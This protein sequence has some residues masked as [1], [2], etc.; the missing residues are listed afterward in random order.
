VTASQFTRTTDI[1]DTHGFVQF[2]GSV[3]DFGAALISAFGDAHTL[4]QT[5]VDPNSDFTTHA[6]VIINDDERI[7]SVP[8]NSW[9]GF[10]GGTWEQR[11]PSEMNGAVYTQVDESGG[12]SVSY[13]PT[14][15][16]ARTGPFDPARS[17]YNQT[18][19]NMQLWRAWLGRARGGLAGV[20]LGWIGDSIT[21]GYLTNIGTEDPVS[22]LRDLIN[23][24]DYNPGE[25]V[26]L[27]NSSV[28][29]SRVERNNW[30]N[31]TQAAPYMSSTAGGQTMT[32]TSTAKGTVVEILS[33]GDGSAFTYSIDGGDPVTVTGTSG[34][35]ILTQVTGLD[36]TTHTVVLTATATGCY[37]AAVGVNDGT[38][39][40]LMNAAQSGSTTADW[41]GSNAYYD[42]INM[43]ISGAAPDVCFVELGGNDYGVLGLDATT[44]GN[45]LA[46]IVNKL[47]TAGVIVFLAASGQA[48]PE[49]YYPQIYTV[50][51]T[52]NVPLLDFQDL[53]ATLPNDLKEADH[54]HF[55]KAGYAIKAEAWA[56]L[57]QLP[58]PN[59]LA[60]A[61]GG[62]GVPAA[63]FP[64]TSGESNYSRVI[65]MRHDN[66]ATISGYLLLNYFEA[67]KTEAITKI[68]SIAG[69]TPSD[70]TATVQQVGV[71]SVADNGDLT[72]IASIAHDAT[73]WT[74][75]YTD[76]LDDLDVTFDKV[77][78]VTYAIGF[79]AVSTGALCN[80]VGPST[81]S[82]GILADALRR[83][84]PI[85]GLVAGLSALPSTVVAGAI[86][87]G[88]ILQMYFELV[89]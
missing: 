2:G 18:G 47:Q 63:L 66:I 76:Y 79:L 49:D 68:R 28:E 72:L 19:P 53:I 59:T 62:G 37:V 70:G 80:L 15:A 88:G 48:L 29:D 11:A 38:G 61:G 20:R 69:S 23:A 34:E 67:E 54:L 44:Y 14:Y 33:T 6:Q 16:G 89:P 86:A 26:W 71:F 60:T 64:L 85:I 77:A 8:P 17:I 46:S 50:A 81:P 27:W 13:V 78:G 45:H 58:R 87:G 7:F 52:Y 40:I 4:V 21:A 56:D 65:T 84:P 3:A 32:Y 57:L 74:T 9:L 5:Q 75:A 12:T 10:N 41:L 82:L 36:D 73:R 51:D 55:N 24:A 25:L 42:P 1:P 83:D 43:M 22:Q 35:M 30:T 39:F 31:G